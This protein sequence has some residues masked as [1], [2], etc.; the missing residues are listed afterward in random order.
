VSGGYGVIVERSK[1]PAN[2]G[3][4]LRTADNLGAAFVA[5]VARRYDREAS[6]CGQAF[7]RLPIFHFATWAEARDKLPF[8][9]EP[10]AVELVEGAVPLPEFVHPRSAVYLLGPE[11]GS[12]SAEALRGARKTVI[13]SKRCINVAQAGA[14][15]MY[16]R[17]AKIA[18]EHRPRR[19][20]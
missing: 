7:R 9:W 3:T 11:D 13:P 10:V 5:T 16:D 15:V 14:I 17:V 4:L 1:T 8:A 6:D 20:A 2:L 19:I 18:A 12:L